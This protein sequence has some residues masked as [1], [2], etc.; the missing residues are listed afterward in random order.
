MSTDILTEPLNLTVALQYLS[1]NLSV[2][3]VYGKAYSQGTTDLAKRP[4]I[5]WTDFQKC[6]LLS[7]RSLFGGI[8][9]PL[10]A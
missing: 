10:L 1:N 8:D 9:S 6:C 4:L 5:K 2:I 7:K 3:P